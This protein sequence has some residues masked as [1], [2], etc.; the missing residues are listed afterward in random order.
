MDKKGYKELI[1]FHIKI[2]NDKETI[3]WN[4]IK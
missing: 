2:Y 3:P 1:P 4:N